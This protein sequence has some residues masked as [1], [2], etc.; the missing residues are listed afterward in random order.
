MFFSKEKK[1]WK[2]E[3]RKLNASRPE[4]AT[5]EKLDKFYEPWK[6]SLAKGRSPMADAQPWLSFAA[7]EL[8]GN[9]ITKEM[10]VFEFG[11][12]GSTLYFAKRVAEVV[13][14]EHDAEWFPMIGKSLKE[15]G[16]SNWKGMLRPAEDGGDASA[17]IADPDAY[18][19]DDAAYKG[20]Q[21]RSYASAIDTW[22]D[23]HFDLVIVDGRAR[24]S[25][26]KHA[27]G[28]IKPGGLLVLDNSD[29]AYYT[30]KTKSL[31]EPLF[32]E[33]LSCKGPGPYLE[34]FTQTTIWKKR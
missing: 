16:C 6:A 2:E 20:K 25:C 14:V 12:G 18:I 5:A 23:A 9:F 26:L 27:L 1:I 33:L 3:V 19:S 29:R 30:E 10:A 24:P 7:I 21:F 28:K 17:S 13:T 11:G 15:N 4:C 8:I 31:V 22:A 34:W 32:V